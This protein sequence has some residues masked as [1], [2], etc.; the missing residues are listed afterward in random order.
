[1]PQGDGPITPAV[2]AAE[3]SKLL[4]RPVHGTAVGF[5]RLHRLVRFVHILQGLWPP[6]QFYP[7]VIG[8]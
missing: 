7:K 3:L 5:S 4:Q 8:S 6:T 1:M 2:A